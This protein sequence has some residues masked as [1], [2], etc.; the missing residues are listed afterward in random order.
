MSAGRSFR[1]RLRPQGDQVRRRAHDDQPAQPRLLDIIG[2]M[3]LWVA[4]GVGHVL[5]PIPDDAA[6]ELKDALVARRRASLTGACPACGA[7]VVVHGG[8]RKLRDAKPGEIVR[9]TMAHDDWCVASDAGIAQL[10]E[11]HGGAS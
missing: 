10:V 9:G 1:R 4:D 8:D 5:P 6:S 7:G 2:G 3:E 11:R